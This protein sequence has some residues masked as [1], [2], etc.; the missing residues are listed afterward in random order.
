MRSIVT[1]TLI[2]MH[3][4]QLGIR[5]FC[6]YHLKF[7]STISSGGVCPSKFFCH[8][9]NSTVGTSISMSLSVR[10]G[11]FSST[12]CQRWTNVFFFLTS[13]IPN[14]KA[15]CLETPSGMGFLGC[16]NSLRGHVIFC[17][18]T[19]SHCMLDDVVTIPGKEYFQGEREREG[20]VMGK[21]YI[22]SCS[23]GHFC[24]PHMILNFFS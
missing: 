8:T 2:V 9:N 17:L 19:R 23:Y 3:P 5:K 1:G 11:V 14:L 12:F 24:I 7:L 15:G 10:V 4:F 21:C 22:P 20:I 16:E 18:Y 13:T 6:G